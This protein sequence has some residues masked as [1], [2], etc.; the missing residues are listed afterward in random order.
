MSVYKKMKPYVPGM[1]GILI[2]AFLLIIGSSVALIAEYQAIYLFLKKILVASGL[3]GLSHL[4]TILCLCALAYTVIYFIGCM[5]THR[6]AFRLE[7]N[8]KKAGM[9]ALL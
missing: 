8:L 5:A 1:G 7:A 2:L 4:V 6:I 3:E 9:D